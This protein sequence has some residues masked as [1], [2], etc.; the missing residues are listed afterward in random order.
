MNPKLLVIVILISLSTWGYGKNSRPTHMRNLT[1][2]SIDSLDSSVPQPVQ[3][4]PNDDTNSRLL[5]SGDAEEDLTHF[6]TISRRMGVDIGMLVPFGDFQKDFGMAP[7]IGLHLSWE[8]SPPFSFILGFMRS[9]SAQKDIANSAKLAINVINLGAMATFPMKRTLPFVKL[10][11]AFYFNDVSFNDGTRYVTSGD[12]L[13][14]TTVGVN[15]GIGIDFVVGREVSLGLEMTYH[16]AI[17]KKLNLSNSTTFDLGSPFAT[18]GIR[19][20]F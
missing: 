2:S 19:V 14:L 12:D 11:G 5:T 20:N 18:A 3:L 15:A 7:L 8:A 16:Y 6:H 1:S 13:I 4:D 10:E 9:A 17:P